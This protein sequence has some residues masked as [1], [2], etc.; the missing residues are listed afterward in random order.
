M[1]DIAPIPYRETV[2]EE[3]E[4]GEALK[5]IPEVRGA[6]DAYMNVAGV[7]ALS[8]YNDL[9]RN[10]AHHNG[11]DLEAAANVIRGAALDALMSIG[12][13]SRG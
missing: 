7:G 5:E 1:H 6:A 4:K 2:D 10:I 3:I 13:E 12:Y 8:N 11:R 9:D